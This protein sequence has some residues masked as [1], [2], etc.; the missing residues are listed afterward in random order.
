M[1]KYQIHSLWN[2]DA[3]RFTETSKQTRTT[4]LK[5]ARAQ[6]NNRHENLKTYVNLKNTRHEN[7][8]TRQFEKYPTWKPET[9]RLSEK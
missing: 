7:F 1:Q 9:L 8:K 2:S 6:S 4:R 3:P 5:K